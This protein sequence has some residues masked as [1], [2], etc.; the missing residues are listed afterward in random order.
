MSCGLAVLVP[1]HR[2]LCLRDS[3]SPVEQIDFYFDAVR[4]KATWQRRSYRRFAAST[5]RSALLAR[6]ITML[7]WMNLS[8]WPS[9]PTRLL[10]K[11]TRYRHM[12]IIT[13][14]PTVANESDSAASAD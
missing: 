13:R 2:A 6:R 10:K 5:A 14:D 4:A 7:C 8:R 3:V 11:I 1:M 9:M 12:G